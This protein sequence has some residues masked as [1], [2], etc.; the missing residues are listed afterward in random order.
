MVD[1]ASTFTYLLRS[2][3]LL[4]RN[5]DE[6]RSKKKH[7]RYKNDRHII[8][9]GLNTKNLLFLFSLVNKDQERSQKHI[10]VEPRQNN[11]VSYHKT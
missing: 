7:V 2:R 5:I 8:D 3:R 1:F 4:F 6:N 9:E 11:S 10:S